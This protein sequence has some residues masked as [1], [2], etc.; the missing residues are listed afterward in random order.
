MD[1]QFAFTPDNPTP[2]LAPKG[3][4]EPQLDFSKQRAAPLSLKI[5]IPTILDPAER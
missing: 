5:D 3:F 4:N 1:L 2:K